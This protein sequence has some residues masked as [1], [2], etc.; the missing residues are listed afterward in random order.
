MILLLNN[1]QTPIFVE[2]KQGQFIFVLNLKV[3]AKA[4]IEL[5]QMGLQLI[6]FNIVMDLP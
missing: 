4:L 5:F 3:L 6:F 2:L 1:I